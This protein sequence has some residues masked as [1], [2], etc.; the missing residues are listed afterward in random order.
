MKFDLHEKTQKASENVD[1]FNA[2]AEY[3]AIIDWKTEL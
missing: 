3:R 1:S 2:T